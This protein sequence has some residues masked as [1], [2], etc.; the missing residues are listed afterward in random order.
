MAKK[1]TLKERVEYLRIGMGLVG[2][3]ANDMTAELIV[4]LY[5]GIS[6]KWGSFN[7]EDAAKIEVEVTGKYTQKEVKA[8]PA[9]GV[10]A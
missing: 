3:P 7:L 6:Q 5:M 9:E 1:L 4:R 2:I 8:E 10:P